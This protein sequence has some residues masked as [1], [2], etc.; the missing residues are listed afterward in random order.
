MMYPQGSLVP[1]ARL[2][3]CAGPAVADGGVCVSIKV[4]MSRDRPSRNAEDGSTSLNGC[5]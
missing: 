5:G 1:I 4:P 3:G 2:V